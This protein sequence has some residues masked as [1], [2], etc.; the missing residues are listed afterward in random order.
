MKNKV[1][2]ITG[3]SSGI[4]KACAFAFGKAGAKVVI[5]GRDQHRLDETAAAL[6]QAGIECLPIAGD[7]SKEAEVKALIEKTLETFHRIDILIN[8]AGISMRALFEDLELDVIRQVM[9]INF[10]GTVYATKYALP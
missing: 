5:T 2:I 1:V 6:R 7:V 10:Y 4:G 8:N 9:D 3:A